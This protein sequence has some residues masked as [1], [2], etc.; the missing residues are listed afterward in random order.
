MLFSVEQAFVGREEI[1]APLKTPAWEATVPYVGWVWCWFLLSP[2]GS[3]VFPSPYKP[4]F[5]NSIST[6]NGRQRTTRWMC[7]TCT[8]SLFASLGRWEERRL[9]D[10]SGVCKYSREAARK[11]T[12][13]CLNLI[14][15]FLYPRNTYW[16]QV[17]GCATSKWLF[18]C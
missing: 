15:I 7:Q 5:P 17:C 6:R 12:P 16:V 14:P 1:R 10:L 4:T 18:I 3:L 9:D 8:H 13:T 2:R 11:E